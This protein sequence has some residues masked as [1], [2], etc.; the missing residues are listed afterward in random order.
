METAAIVQQESAVQALCTD[1]RI[2]GIAMNQ[3]RRVLYRPYVPI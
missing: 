1:I 3:H 2:M